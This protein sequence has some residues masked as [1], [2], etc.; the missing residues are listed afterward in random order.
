VGLG[1]DL[2]QL[3]FAI[4][5]QIEVIWPYI[6]RSLQVKGDKR[7]QDED[8]V[9]GGVKNKQDKK[10]VVILSHTVEHPWTMA[11]EKGDM[12]ISQN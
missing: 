2:R 7:S 9:N 3:N 8:A 10:L 6:V 11:I 4:R 5:S 1:V 12:Q